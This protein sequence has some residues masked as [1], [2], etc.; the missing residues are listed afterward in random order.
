MMDDGRGRFS[1]RVA[2]LLARVV[3]VA[4]LVGALVPGRRDLGVAAM[5]VAVLLAMYARSQGVRRKRRDRGG[6][7]TMRS[8]RMQ[9][10]IYKPEPPRAAGPSS[11]I[12][13]DAV[14]PL[15]QAFISGVLLTAVIVLAVQVFGDVWL[16]WPVVG[17]LLAGVTSVAWLFV[18]WRLLWRIEEATGI[19]LDR[20]GV[21]GD[22]AR[23]GVVLVNAGPGRVVTPPNPTE[24][25]HKRMVEFAE[26]A[27]I[28]TSRRGLDRRGFKRPEMEEMRGMLMRCRFAE[29]D[30]PDNTSTTA[31]W[32]LT[33]SAAEISAR[34]L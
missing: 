10:I 17:L 15:L 11:L 22:P 18:A 34:L 23:A 33:K 4:G 19:D 25:L 31:G 12:V 30:S 8:R 24:V 13:E 26:A 2:V 14:V 6:G 3:G 7:G 1:G 16:T 27:E 5:L 21:V 9:D 20:D 28:G 29:W 32:H